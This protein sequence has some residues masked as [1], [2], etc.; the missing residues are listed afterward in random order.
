MTQLTNALTS[1]VMGNPLNCTL[2]RKGSI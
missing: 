1:A 2:R